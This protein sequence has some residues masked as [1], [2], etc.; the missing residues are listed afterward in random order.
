MNG[1]S[2][3]NCCNA[4]KVK[5][6]GIPVPVLAKLFL[7]QCKVK[8]D[9]PKQELHQMLL[10][11]LKQ[12]FRTL[13]TKEY[14]CKITCNRFKYC[15]IQPKDTKM[16]KYLWSKPKILKSNRN[17]QSDNSIILDTI[18]SSSPYSPATSQSNM[19]LE[20]KI[21]ELQNELEKLNN[22]LEFIKKKRNRIIKN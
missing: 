18:E 16:G 3:L 7:K 2:N 17:E 8:K 19:Q 9:I 20:L 13:I 5:Y 4:N 6:D 22:E 21:A 11:Q 14:K 10:T 1:Y 15:N 12:Q